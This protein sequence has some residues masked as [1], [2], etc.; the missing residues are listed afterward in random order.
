[1]RRL[2][3]CDLFS[4]CQL[5]H[6]K[7]RVCNR[8]FKLCLILL[9]AA[10]LILFGLYTASQPIGSYPALLP[11]SGTSLF[12]RQPLVSWNSNGNTENVDS[13]HI[14]VLLTSLAQVLF[15]AASAF[16]GATTPLFFELG[17]EVTYPSNEGVSAGLI[18]GMLNLVCYLV[19]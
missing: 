1:M 11:S 14:K 13:S 16:L 9:F 4:S 7:H 15:C 3:R 12:V 10:Q 19:L 17:A 2:N 5:G 18:S 8:R 6:L